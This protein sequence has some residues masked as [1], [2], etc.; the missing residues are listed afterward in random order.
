MV[1]FGS[2]DHIFE[3]LVVDNGF[4][5]WCL[6]GWKNLGKC[7]VQPTLDLTYHVYLV[8]FPLYTK[9]KTLEEAAY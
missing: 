6:L 7:V 8:F 4:A 9:T 1:V 5:I 3:S 2:D